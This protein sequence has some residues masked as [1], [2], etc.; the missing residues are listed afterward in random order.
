[1]SK[2]TPHNQFSAYKFITPFII[3][4]FLVSLLP[5]IIGLFM[6]FHYW[7][8]LE[9]FKGENID[10]VGVDNYFLIYD[11]KNINSLFSSLIVFLV[12]SVLFI[13]FFALLFSKLITYCFK[14]SQAWILLALITP[15]V[16]SELALQFG[17]GYIDI[18]TRAFAGLDLMDVAFEDAWVEIYKLAGFFTL[19]YYMV[20]KSVPKN[21]LEAA[22]LEGASIVKVFFAIELPHMK[23][24]ISM[25][26][27]LSIVMLIGKARAVDFMI[28]FLWQAGDMGL[29]SVFTWTYVYLLLIIVFL[30]FVY[31]KI[32][33]AL[34]EKQL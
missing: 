12:V 5:Y 23:K 20:L 1:M 25:M 31:K 27:V 4:F 33:Q 14:S 8:L 26:F 24:M 19:I 11:E 32:R 7:F 2:L 30:I 21:I 28:Q 34:K 10:F 17:A 3:I 29:A 13:H 15:Y 18:K 22:K 9:E 16:V 6:S